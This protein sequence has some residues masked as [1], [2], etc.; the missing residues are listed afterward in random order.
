MGAHVSNAEQRRAPARAVL[1]SR[2]AVIALLRREFYDTAPSTPGGRVLTGDERDA[3]V[4]YRR[5]HNARALSLIAW[6]SQGDVEAGLQEPR[7]AHVVEPRCAFE[8]E[9]G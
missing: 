2:S 9:A 6:L 5:G 7:G 3:E 4:A 8:G 1:V